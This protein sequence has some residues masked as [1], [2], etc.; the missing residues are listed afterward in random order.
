[1]DGFFATLFI[2][3]LVE[4]IQPIFGRQASLNDFLLGFMGVLL[5]FLL[6]LYWQ[7]KIIRV[8]YVIRSIIL[9]C[10]ILI[11]SLFIFF[12]IYLKEKEFP[13]LGSF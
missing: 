6:L 5:G 8:P 1:M 12:A 2:L 13:V 9:T 4:I 7:I 10:L 11:K 3:L